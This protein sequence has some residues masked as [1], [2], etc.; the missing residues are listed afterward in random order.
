MLTRRSFITNTG[1]TLAQIGIAGA[2]SSTNR[3]KTL[4]TFDLH[5]HPR[6]LATFK[7]ILEN[8]LQGAFIA[9]VADL[10]LLRR[11]ETGIVPDGKFQPGE[12]WA[13]FEAQWN[14]YQSYFSQT[15][16]IPVSSWKAFS[17]SRSR[18]NFAPF[19]AC[20][21]ADFLDGS[22]ENLDR[23]YT[24][25]L[26]SVQ[27]VHYVPNA[28]G[29]LQTFAPQHNGLSAFGKSA[30]QRMNELGMVID[31]AHASY[32]TVK[33]VVDTSSD[34]VI[35]SHSI[36]KKPPFSPISARALTEDHARII[37]QHGGVIGMW[38]SGLS[39]DL[40]E[41]ADS[42]LRMI[43]LVGINHVGIGTD[44]DANY[45]PVIKNYDDFYSWSDLL[46]EKGLQQEEIN[47][48]TG[49]NALRVLK[50]VLG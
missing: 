11:T 49:G 39:N 21:G 28:L 30:V 16:I 29:D 35:L 47:K 17:Q 12:A 1:A 2:L 27:L 9:L 5:C 33:G 15:G 48:L 38:P 44:M 46:A 43:D 34:P 6:S 24:M 13:E 3:K 50:K 20:E 14:Q 10:P 37:A 26:R 18:G 22:L 8:H 25:G 40:D 42:T 32:D 19:L 36:L 31:V 41:F 45:K 23:A 7:N 4:A